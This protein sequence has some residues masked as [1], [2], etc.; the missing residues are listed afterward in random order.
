VYSFDDVAGPK[1][2]L[3]A[4]ICNHCPFVLHIIE[5]FVAFAR[6]YQPKGLG[7]V[8]ISSN[9]ADAFPDD[10]FERMAE[11]ARVHRFSFPYLYDETQQ[12]AI[13]Y[14]A[15]CTPDFF[16][17]D[18]ERRLAYGGQ[19]D[20]SRPRTPHSSGAATELPVTGRDMRAAADAVLQGH[21][22]PQPH[23]PSNGCSM[24]WKPGNAP[25]WA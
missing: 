2:T 25:A 10:S 24:K 18:R 20:G 15:V 7:I 1:G 11:F 13:A 6:E 17:F 3:V 8:A 22:V 4:F 12:I 9:D 14:R 16:L 21:P 19:F 23:R 5:G